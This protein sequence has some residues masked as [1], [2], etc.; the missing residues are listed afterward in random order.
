MFLNERDLVE[1]LRMGL[2]ADKGQRRSEASNL[3]KAPQAAVRLSSPRCISPAE[4]ECALSPQVDLRKQLG[5]MD[6][7]QRAQ[8]LL[9]DIATM[10]FYADFTD[11]EGHHAHT[12]L[13]MLAHESPNQKHIK[14]WTSTEKAK[15]G[16]YLVLHV[17][18][19]FYIESF[20]YLVMSKGTLLLTSDERMQQTIKTFAVPLSPEMAPVATV[21]VYYVGRYG[22][23]VADSLTFPVNGISRNNFTVFINNKK[24][25]TG[26]NVE[27]R[28][29][30]LLHG[31]AIDVSSRGRTLTGNRPVI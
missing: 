5:L 13:L 20:N 8:Q 18:T 11:G 31:F 24:A 16:E 7:P 29:P 10:R 21:V 23:V 14:V 4:C 25:R 12:E 30:F 28:M 17:Q 6:N 1:L 22:D 27:V 15:V 2:S 3:I 19:N 9:N 26:E